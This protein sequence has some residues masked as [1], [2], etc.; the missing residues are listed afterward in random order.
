GNRIQYVVTERLTVPDRFDV[1]TG[2]VEIVNQTG[3]S[4]ID[5]P[6]SAHF[7]VMSFGEN[8]QGAHTRDGRMLECEVNDS[9]GENCDLTCFVPV[10]SP[11]GTPA[12]CNIESDARYR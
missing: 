8:A 4:A 12:T 1:A 6:S 11:P 7:F 2:G 3:A 10:G 9:E 5:P